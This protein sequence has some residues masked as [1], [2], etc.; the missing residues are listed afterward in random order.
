MHDLASDSMMEMLTYEEKEDRKGQLDKMIKTY[1]QSEH[2]ANK[3]SSFMKTTQASF[4]LESN[5]KG[6][7]NYT[8]DLA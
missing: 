6:Q 1:N 8:L 2:V 4:H 3:L 7:A 5:K